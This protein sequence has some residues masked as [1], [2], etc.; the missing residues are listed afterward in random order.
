MSNDL[1]KMH[2]ADFNLWLEEVKSAIANQNFENMDWDNLIDEIDDMGASQKRALDSYMKRLIEHLLK[3]KFWHQEQERNQRSWRGEVN[4]FRDSINKI[5]K[6]N[7]SLKNYLLEEYE[8]N[9]R[10]ATRRVGE[11]FEIPKDCFWELE[12]TMD[13]E[14]YG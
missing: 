9:F 11:L 7:P 3:L 14:F 5:I 4:A 2:E 8:D 1:K 12:K 6:K 10:S 13:L